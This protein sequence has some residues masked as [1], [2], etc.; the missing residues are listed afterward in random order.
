MRSKHRG[1]LKAF[2][3][4]GY[5]DGKGIPQQ[6]RSDYGRFGTIARG[7]AGLLLRIAMEEEAAE[8]LGRLPF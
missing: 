4:G 7:G 3:K 6:A 8:F 5:T 1:L 2:R